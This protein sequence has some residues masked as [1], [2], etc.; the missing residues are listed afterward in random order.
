ML[1]STIIV[2]LSVFMFTHLNVGETVSLSQTFLPILKER[3]DTPEEDTPTFL[4]INTNFSLSEST[5]PISTNQSKRHSS[6]VFPDS[7][8]QYRDVIFPVDA[9]KCSTS[10]TVCEDVNNYPY[11]R[12][13]FT[14]SE[15]HDANGFFG[16]DEGTIEHRIGD[17]DDNFICASIEK[18]IFPKAGKNKYNK[19]KYIINQ[20][21]QEGYVQGVRIETCAKLNGP[22][23]LL[24]STP[25]GF[26][27]SCK[28]KYIYRRLLSVSDN[29]MPTTDTFQIPSACCCSYRRNNDYLLNFGR[30]VS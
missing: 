15:H 30:K 20:G 21:D 22:C 4:D 19:W 17:L 28:Q 24:G 12:I 6:I 29:G 7:V 14:L 27:T 3:A 11:E 2:L 25:Y 10:T 8:E 9:S 16:V 5:T 1:L 13:K 26:I 23:N 18:T